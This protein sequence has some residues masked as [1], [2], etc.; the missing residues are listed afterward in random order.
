MKYLMFENLA[1][2]VCSVIGFLSGIRYLNT[3]KVIFAGMIVQG[4]ICIALGRLFQSALLWTGGSLTEHFQLGGLGTMGAF[5]FFFSANFG[6]IDSLAD[7]GRQEFKKY[8][9]IALFVQL[10]VVAMVAIIAMSPAAL[11]YKISCGVVGWIIGAACYFHVKHLLI[12]DVDYGVVRCLRRYN[13]LAVTLSVLTM[14]E[15]ITLAW[16]LEILLYVSGVGLCVV[17]LVLVPVMGRGVKKW[18]T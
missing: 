6:Q 9:I 8:R 7:D 16:N 13:A 4:V 3:Q 11:G 12:P 17:S 10:Y 18:T 2:L 5:T 15:M 14:L 1:I